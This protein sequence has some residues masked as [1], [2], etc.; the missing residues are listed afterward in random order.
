MITT[1]ED[2]RSAKICM[3]GARKWCKNNNINWTNF[4]INGIDSNLL[5]NYDDALVKAILEQTT[6]R[7]NKE[8]NNE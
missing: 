4:C 5:K 6:I 3:K 2:I 8:I 1:I 7:M